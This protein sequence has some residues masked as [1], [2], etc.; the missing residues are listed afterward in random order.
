MLYFGDTI[1]LLIFWSWKIKHTKQTSLH[2]GQCIT[3][4]PGFIG[5]VQLH[6]NRERYS[7]SFLP[8]SHHHAGTLLYI[9]TSSLK[10]LI[11]FLFA[12]FTSWHSVYYTDANSLYTYCGCSSDH[13]YFAAHLLLLG[14]GYLHLV[15]ELVL[16]VLPYF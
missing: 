8:I 14:H 12:F 4:L 10:K 16:T 2:S 6:C 9:T 15:S 13:I 3:S 1:Q 7:K 11:G 5:L